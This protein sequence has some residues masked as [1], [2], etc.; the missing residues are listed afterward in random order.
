[1]VGTAKSTGIAAGMSRPRTAPGPSDAPPHP[2]DK[3]GMINLEGF[4]RL[5]GYV[6]YFH[7][8]DEAAAA[9]WNALAMAGVEQVERAAGPA[10]LAARLRALFA[11]IAPTVEISAAR[12]PP[13]LGPRPNAI[14]YMRWHHVGLGSNGPSQAYKSVRIAG[15][16]PRPDDML[17]VALPGG[18]FARIPLAV[19]VGADGKTLPAATGRPPVPARPAGYIPSGFDRT[20]RLAAIIEGWN[21]FQHFY[22]YFDVV[23]TDWPAALR[24]GLAAAATDRDDLAFADTLSRLTAALH[25]GHAGIIYPSPD[26]AMLPV[27]WD[28]VESKLVVTA[29]EPGSG[30]TPGDV[31]TRIDGVPAA[32]AIAR[33]ERLSS[34]SPQFVRQVAMRKLRRGPP[35]RP[36]LLD[37]ASR[38]GRTHGV[39]L[40]HKAGAA[41]APGANLRPP[42]DWIEP[43][44]LYVD[45]SRATE[46]SMRSHEA[47]FTRARA[48]IYD[49]RRYPAVPPVFLPH[50]T[51]RTI[52]SARFDEPTWLAPDHKRVVYEDK[53]WTIIPEA[54]RYT[55]DVIFL[56]GPSAVSYAE[57]V[58]GV[59]S[60]NRL[61]P[62][63]GEP[64][65]G[66]N[67]DVNIVDVAGGY[68][69]RWT[70]LRVVNRDGSQ[71]HL[72]GVRP[73][74]E[75][76]QTIAGIRAGRDEVLE[77][78]LAIARAHLPPAQERR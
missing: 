75:V 46:A 62:I 7:P 49:V 52:R 50:L 23:K 33:Q 64:S 8:S 32:A 66:T 28:W 29:A 10:E 41:G 48:L 34:G 21:V 74:I 57:S 38:D 76:H 11:P 54:P 51:S 36:A 56:S 45:L 63:V 25:D 43:G 22:P 44:I 3:R 6:R 37:V 65:A 69:L 61:A 55:S 77:R 78:A 9:D 26:T 12:M 20:T 18:V 13:A 31:V 16:L 59:V 60:N 5:Y 68:R 42:F 73:T 53:A 19:A 39:R 17:A 2:L 70:G 1:V 4:A 35:D 24:A 47:D 67:G 71:H 40:I 30:L 72:V 27:D 14:H 58:L 15:A